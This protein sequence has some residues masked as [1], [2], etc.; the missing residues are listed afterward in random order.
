MSYTYLKIRDLEHGTTDYRPIRKCVDYNINGYGAFN[1]MTFNTAFPDLLSK[2]KGCTLSIGIPS[3][4]VWLKAPNLYCRRYIYGIVRKNRYQLILKDENNVEYDSYILEFAIARGWA[5]Q[6]T[7][8]AGPIT[9]KYYKQNCQVFGLFRVKDS[10]DND[11]TQ[12]IFGDPTSFPYH[13]N[14]FQPTDS[15]YPK[16]WYTC[17]HLLYSQNVPSYDVNELSNATDVCY[18]DYISYNHFN[19]SKFTDLNMIWDIY[20]CFDE[21]RQQYFLTLTVNK[22]GFHRSQNTSWLDYANKYAEYN[23]NGIELELNNDDDFGVYPTRG[24]TLYL[25][26]GVNPTFESDE[27]VSSGNDDGDTDTQSTGTNAT[28]YGHGIGE[29]STEYIDFPSLT[30]TN[31]AISSGLY[32]IVKMNQSGLSDLASFLWSTN[33]IDTLVKVFSKP[34]DCI[35][36][37]LTLPY[38]VTADTNT[39]ELTILDYP[40]GVDVSKNVY[41]A[42]SVSFG[43]CNCDESFGSFLDYDNTKVSIFLPYIGMQPLDVQDVMDSILTLVYNID[44]QNGQCVAMLKCTKNNMDVDSVT[45]SWSGNL[46]T[47]LPL[48]GVDNT[49]YLQGL[50]SSV[51]S[52]A[53]GNV[54]GSIANSVN[55]V[56]MGDKAI[57]KS[58]RLDCNTG[59]LGIMYPYIKV[60]RPVWTRPDNYEEIHGM[61]YDAENSISNMSGFVKFNVVNVES[62]TATDA[63]KEKIKDL[64]TEGIII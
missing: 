2:T 5:T 12:S 15:Y 56:F 34:F 38:D 6:E 7:V 55:T 59:N 26:E 23:V 54:G 35:V 27:D 22:D 51:S 29:D 32:R 8:P 28:N 3:R 47:Q 58:G 48:N 4:N 14:K 39:E 13:V 20:V 16:D 52:V 18:A 44:N 19:S 9:P 62:S 36:S 57:M 37:L 31:P 43:S 46:A 42:E 33:V 45:Y 21:N 25:G 53:M 64:L 50:I 40:T 24:R 10:N 17:I 60:E 11:V 61:P 63:E 41:A 30:T 49:Q 1:S